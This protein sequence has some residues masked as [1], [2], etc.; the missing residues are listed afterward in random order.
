MGRRFAAIAIIL[1]FQ[2][3]APADEIS[4]QVAGEDGAAGGYPSR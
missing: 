2:A 3:A 4:D 1:I